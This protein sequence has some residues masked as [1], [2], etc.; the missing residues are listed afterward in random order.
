MEEE[1]LTGLVIVNMVAVMIVSG[2]CILGGVLS[3]SIVLNL[4]IK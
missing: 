1:T 4:I 3:M 2:L